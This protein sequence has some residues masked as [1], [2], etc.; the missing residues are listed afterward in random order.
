MRNNTVNDTTTVADVPDLTIAKTHPGTFTRGGTG[1]YTI[2]HGNSR[3]T[4]VRSAS[5]ESTSALVARGAQAA[6][7]P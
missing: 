6:R 5:V 7:R 2:T 1:T 3:R 4:P